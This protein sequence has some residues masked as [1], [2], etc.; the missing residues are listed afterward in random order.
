MP[1]GTTKIAQGQAR[2]DPSNRYFFKFNF[3]Y[4]FMERK[5]KF[6]KNKFNSIKRHCNTKRGEYHIKKSQN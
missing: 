2:T 3:Y 4:Y 1:R 6:K 5:Q